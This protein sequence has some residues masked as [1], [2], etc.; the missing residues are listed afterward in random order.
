MA[1]DEITTSETA[2]TTESTV[3]FFQFPPALGVPNA[4][5]FCVKLECWLRMAEIPYETKLLADPRKAP[6]GKLPMVELEGLKTSDS[7]CAIEVLE[8]HF[9]KRL[10]SAM[11][12]IERG[13]ALALMRMLEEHSY[14]ALIY[15][16]WLDDEIWPQTRET[17]FA[18]MNPVVRSMASN[19]VRKKTR[20][21]AMGQGLAR[22]SRDEILHRFNEDM[23][24]LAAVLSEKPY[25]GGYQPARV[26]ASVY[27]LLCN[28]L[29]A[30]MHLPLTDIARQHSN[31]IAHTDR[32]RDA[33]FPEYR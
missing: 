26:D 2:T 18:N 1:E 22:H 25:F 3:K 19:A 16:R 9:D 28:V 23:N 30:E 7:T 10:E 31:L 6:L 29:H 12:V 4:S 13:R 24:A 15:F 33:Y 21:D 5:P 32:M 8:K 14:W 20:R 27:G 17:F 11:N